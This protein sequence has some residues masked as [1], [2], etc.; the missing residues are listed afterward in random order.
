MSSKTVNSITV[1]SGC[2]IEVS[3]TQY[4]IKKSDG[5]YGSYQTGATFSGL[6]PNTAYVVEV[7]K[8]GKV[9]GEAATATI[10]VTTYDIAR[11]TSYPNFNL[12]DSVTVNYSN[13]SGAAIQVGLYKDGQTALAAY[14]NCSGSS[15]TFNFTD[16]ELDEIYKKMS[17]NSLDAYFYINTNNNA[18]RE[19]KPIKITLTGNQK[20]ARI[21]VNGNW[22]RAK[23]WIN[24]NGTWKRCVRWININGTWKRCI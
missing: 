10:S 8:V 3:S 4:R 5:S 20:T 1:T 7:K 17:E 23:R 2:N 24:I 22:K 12:G 21:N 16:A 15:Y 9:N 19:S 13:P 14:R 11:L 6:S 18:Y